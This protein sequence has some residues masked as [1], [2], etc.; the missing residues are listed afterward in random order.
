MFETRHGDGR[1]QTDKSIHQFEASVNLQMP[2]LN[3]LLFRKAPS[4]SHMAKNL[5][6]R[7]H[8]ATV[9]MAQDFGSMK[10]EQIPVSHLGRSVFSTF[11]CSFCS[12][13]S[14]LFTHPGG[15]A[16]CIVLCVHAPKLSIRT[17]LPLCPTPGCLV[18]L[19]EGSGL[20][21]LSLE[22]RISVGQAGAH[23]PGPR[24]FLQSRKS[25]KNV[26]VDVYTTYTPS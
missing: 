15:A 4:L 12:N 11:F 16:G 14:I 10:Q 22:N 24:S 19:C 9:P 1:K 5:P 26:L 25:S 23:E 7:T 17:R 13:A 18:R 2:R 6:K 21:E 8:G 20:A 3:K